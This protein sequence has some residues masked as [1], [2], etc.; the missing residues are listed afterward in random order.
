MANAGAVAVANDASTAWHNPA[1]MTHVSGTQLQGTAGLLILNIKFD[2]DSDTPVR[3]G[4]KG[5]RGDDLKRVQVRI[6][7][8]DGQRKNLDHTEIMSR[9]L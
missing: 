6:Y 5:G 8:L 2:A 9:A 1:G 7:T 3:G 4:Q